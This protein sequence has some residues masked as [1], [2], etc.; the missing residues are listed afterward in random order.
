MKQLTRKKI[1]EEAR[2]LGATRDQISKWRQRGLSDRWRII[3]AKHFDMKAH[4]LEYQ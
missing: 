4:E 3:L 2:K 1:E